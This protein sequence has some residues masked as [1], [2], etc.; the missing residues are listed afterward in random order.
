MAAVLEQHRL[1]IFANDAA[2]RYRAEGPLV[3]PRANLRVVIPR[4]NSIVSGKQYLGLSISDVFKITDARF[5][6]TGEGFDQVTVS[7]ALPYEYGWIGVW[8]TT[9]FPDGHYE[10]QAVASDSRGH[11]LRSAEVAVT[12]RN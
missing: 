12:I 10:L 9:G 8:T 4:A 7:R 3:L 2:A 6:A 1:T 11:R 5:E